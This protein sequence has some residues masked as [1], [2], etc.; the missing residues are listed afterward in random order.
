MQ[1]ITTMSNSEMVLSHCYWL[2]EFQVHKENGLMH[3]PTNL[4]LSLETPLYS[5][6]M[7]LLLATTGTINITQ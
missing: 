3:C 1:K 6:T 4:L 7:F 2:T 5:Y